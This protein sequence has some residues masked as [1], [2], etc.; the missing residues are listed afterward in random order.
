MNASHLS[1]IAVILAIAFSPLLC[2]AQQTDEVSLQFVSFPKPENPQPIELIVG[3]NKTVPVEI[4]T[5]S[6]SPVYKVN[7]SSKWTLG[8]TVVGEEGNSSF[9]TYGETLSIASKT[10][11]ILVIRSGAGDKDGLT[12]IAIDYEPSE[13]KGGAYLFFNAS[14]TEI[15]GKIGDTKLEITA[16]NHSLVN[17]Q[18]ANAEENKNSI[19]IH[20]LL[21][22]GEDANAFYSST[23]RFNEKARSLIFLFNETHSDRLRIHTIRD[24]LP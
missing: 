10:Q 4:P 23:W 14:K 7:R 12:L 8:K 2:I 16:S 6:L 3:E 19:P 15:T 5:N 24:Y 22:K 21:N 1:R 11:L 13:F 18:P 20:I 9:T 17:P